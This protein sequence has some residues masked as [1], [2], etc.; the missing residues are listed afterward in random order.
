MLQ[1][2]DGLKGQ[3]FRFPMKTG[4]ADTVAKNVVNVS[5][6]DRLR[7]D[8]QGAFQDML[9]EALA[10]TKHHAMFAKKHRLGIAKAREMVDSKNIQILG[11][12]LCEKIPLDQLL[13]RA[14]ADQIQVNADNQM[15][16]FD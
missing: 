7:R 15:N 8:F 13:S 6:A 5:D 1:T 3:F 12:T 4:N 16:L 11:L 9:I 14:I 2:N 10:G